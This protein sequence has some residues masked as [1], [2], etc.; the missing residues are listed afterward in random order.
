VSPPGTTPHGE[1]TAWSP[2]EKLKIVEEE[3]E[4]EEQE[5]EMWEMV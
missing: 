4:E 2:C 1:P 5:E 3:E